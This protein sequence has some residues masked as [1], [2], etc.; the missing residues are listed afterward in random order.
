[1]AK[2]LAKDYLLWVE[3][4][5]PGTY[6]LVKGQQ[7]LSLQESSSSVDTTTKDDYPWST[8]APGSRS[9]TIDFSCVPDLPDS[10]GYT[11]LETIAAATTPQVN[12]QIRKGGA[13][14]TGTDAVFAGL[15]NVVS[16]NTT[17]D[18]N[19]PIA[20]KWQLSNAA[21]PTTNALA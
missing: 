9:V 18:N 5:T 1:M 16:K 17:A 12:I 2:K 14:A 3:S 20:S 4:A 6:N 19:N 7:T 13:S 8:S 11:R 21:A 15:M 10:T